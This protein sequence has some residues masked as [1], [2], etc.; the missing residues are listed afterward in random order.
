[1]I[2]CYNSH[3]LDG[4]P[5]RGRSDGLLSRVSRLISASI[6][7]C[8]HLLLFSLHELL[9]CNYQLLPPQLSSAF[10][11]GRSHVIVNSTN[12]LTRHTDHPRTMSSP[13]QSNIVP[14][15]F[16][17]GQVLLII[18]LCTPILVTIT[19]LAIWCHRKRAENRKAEA[20][21]AA[22]ARI[23]TYEARRQARL[24]AERAWNVDGERIRTL[25]ALEG[26]VP[27]GVTTDRSGY[28]APPL[29]TLTSQAPRYHSAPVTF[30]Q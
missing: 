1:M 18:L 17:K 15:S 3:C 11:S 7:F 14:R 8:H 20:I 25:A 24:E 22:R 28:R 23:A 29:P 5:S 12:K 19:I 16:T 4:Q 9:F 26:L 10:P 30:L 21:L 27:E 6:D 2:R 13:Q